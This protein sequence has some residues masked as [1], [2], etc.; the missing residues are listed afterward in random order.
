MPEDK[1]YRRRTGSGDEPRVLRLRCHRRPFLLFLP[2]EYQRG[3]AY[4]LIVLFHE[5]GSS[6]AGVLARIGY[7]SSRNYI[8]ACPQGSYEVG[9]DMWGRRRWEWG[10]GLHPGQ[11]DG[12]APLIDKVAAQYRLHPQR[13]YVAGIGMGAAVAEQM[14]QLWREQIRGLLLLGPTWPTGERRIDR[15]NLQVLITYFQ[16]DGRPTR[17]FCR[18]LAAAYR[19]GG[20]NVHCEGIAAT[21][22]WHPDMFTVANRWIM[23]QIFPSKRK[24]RTLCPPLKPPLLP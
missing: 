14:G 13:L 9:P 21:G 20:A 16:G 11:L 8:V 12:L 3:Y 18:R 7:L 4:P 19:A 23:E 10:G 15:P 2:E 5:D 6:P 22:P 1:L 24:R 17:G